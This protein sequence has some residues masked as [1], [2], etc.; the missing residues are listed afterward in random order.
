MTSSSNPSL[1]RALDTML[2]VY[3]LLQG[4]PASLACEQFIRARGGWFISLLNLFEAKAVLSKVY[5]V[6]VTDA[7]QKLLQ[8]ATGP[9][10]VVAL[11]AAMAQSALLFADKL[12]IDL[13]DAVLL[14]TARTNGAVWL[15]TEDQR[16]AQVCTQ[17][18]LT[19]ESPLDAALR[20]Q[21]ALWES[22]RLPAKGLPRVLGQVHRWLLANHPQA[23]QDFW[24]RSGGASHLP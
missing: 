3:S 15:A 18:G 19:P 10:E 2:L 14:E 24:T 5:G 16:L 11:D 20:Q 1:E 7:T 12:G 9:I 17:F 13:T 6:S 8:F 22:A 4:H 21:I 23:A